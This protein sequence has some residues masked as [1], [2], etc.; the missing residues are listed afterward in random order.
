M[1][2]AVETNCSIFVNFFSKVAVDRTPRR[3]GNMRAYINAV[4]RYVQVLGSVGRAEEALTEARILADMLKSMQ[5]SYA[6]DYNQ[7]Q[8]MVSDLLKMVVA[9][10]KAQVQ[11]QQQQQKAATKA[12]GAAN[13]KSHGP[14][15]ASKGKNGRRAGGG[16]RH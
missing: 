8:G 12:S 7:V 1:C 15:K 11:Q 3:V 6:A 14:K 16:R 9:G 4:K 10:R 2:N 13:K 5:Q